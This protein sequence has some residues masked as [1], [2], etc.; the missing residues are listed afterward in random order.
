MPRGGDYS[1]DP[2]DYRPDFD[3]R[4]DWRMEQMID[5]ARRELER[6]P[7]PS[8]VACPSCGKYSVMQPDGSI[9]KI[10]KKEVDAERRMTDAAF[11]QQQRA[12]RANRMQRAPLYPPV[13]TKR[14]R[15]KTK[16]D[17]TMSRCLK[18]ANARYRKKNGQLKKGKT[19]SDVMK[20]AHR[21][22]K[23]S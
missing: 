18:M 8:P 11:A 5:D 19:M 9:K 21:L 7:R 4:D 3:R 17:R 10:S 20:L 14:T 22:C 13:N 2:D 15:K 1:F 16:M 6:P 12:R 23:K